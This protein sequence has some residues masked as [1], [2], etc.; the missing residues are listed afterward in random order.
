M[1]KQLN[2]NLAMTA[3]TSQA[4]LQLQQLQRSLTELVNLSNNRTSGGFGITKEIQEA[5]AA[6][7]QLKVQ[8]KAATDVNTGKLDLS[9]FSQQLD[10][11]GMNLTKYQTQLTALGPAGE[12]AFA[13]LATSISNADARISNANSAL[14]QFAVSLKNTARWQ[15]SSS[16]LHGFMGSIQSAYGY[17]QDLNES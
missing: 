17:A 3:D 12:K 6:A 14:S 10:Q 4:K 2:V 11:S 9:K 5:S 1:A 7:A 13:A 15:L 16:V 8:L